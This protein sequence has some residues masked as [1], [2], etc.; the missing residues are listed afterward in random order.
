MRGFFSG[1]NFVCV[2]RGGDFATLG[3]P[4]APTASRKPLHI[5][6]P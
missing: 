6:V 5:E 4:K 2:G 1:E 3:I